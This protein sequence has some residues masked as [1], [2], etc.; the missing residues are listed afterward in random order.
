MQLS[1]WK[2]WFHKKRHSSVADSM[3]TVDK[4]PAMPD[5]VREVIQ[6]FF[7]TYNH[8]KGARSLQTDTF[9]KEV[10]YATKQDPKDQRS[11]EEMEAY[12]QH[13]NV[14][15]LRLKSYVID[16]Y[17][18]LGE[19]IC[20]IGVTREF[21]N[22]HK[23][24]VLYFLIKENNSWK[25]HHIARSHHGT[26][27]DKFQV[28]EQ[29]GFV[30]GND[31]AALLFLTHSSSLDASTFITG[32]YVHAEGYLEVEQ[33]PSSHLYYRVVRMNRVH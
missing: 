19:K 21:S 31:K 22:N 6:Q 15:R 32:D 12:I 14:L 26:I 7:R 8:F 9:I 33:E 20:M 29:T 5:E 4:G 30:V 3:Y 24:R 10:F 28:K 11:V 13:K 23:N 17:L 1:V 27:L 16:E 2:S 25:F 18:S